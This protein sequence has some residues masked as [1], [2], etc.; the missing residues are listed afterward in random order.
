MG[1]WIAL[2]RLRHSDMH[3][4]TCIYTHAH[5]HTYMHTPSLDS[6]VSDTCMRRDAARHLYRDTKTTCRDYHMRAVL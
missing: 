1:A 2:L 4:H 3:T 6:D 5:T